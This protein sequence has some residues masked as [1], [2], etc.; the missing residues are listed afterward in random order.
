MNVVQSLEN[1]WRCQKRN[2]FPAL[3][4]P[5]KAHISTNR[6]AALFR[7][8]YV[9]IG[10]LC[11][12]KLPILFSSINMLRLV[13]K[14]PLSKSTQ[15]GLLLT[16]FVQGNFT[17][18]CRCH[19]FFWKMMYFYMFPYIWSQVSLW[20]VPWLIQVKVMKP[21]KIRKAIFR[22]FYIKIYARIWIHQLILLIS[23]TELR[24]NSYIPRFWQV[25]TVRYSIF[26]FYLYLFIV[27]DNFWN[28]W[29]L[30]YFGTRAIASDHF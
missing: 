25:S 7:H 17:S 16:Q 28:H 29:K 22:K 20:Q 18:K 6:D 14:L 3:F 21:S 10:S 27:N 4:F 23:R 12:Y 26:T 5:P 30:S 1:R 24:G 2:L 13:S 11:P 8:G 19:T 9:K 15:L